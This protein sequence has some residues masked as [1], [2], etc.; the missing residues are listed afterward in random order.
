MQNIIKYSGLNNLSEEEQSIVKTIVEKEYPKIQ[1][2]IK[3][4]SDLTI[5]IKTMKKMT[6]KRFMINFKLE[7]PGIRFNAKTRD[8]ERG[9]DWDLAKACHKALEGLQ[10]EIK[11]R[12]KTDMEN[13]KKGSIKRTYKYLKD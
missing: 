11:H 5:N 8:T 13:W 9:G 7:A 6:R 4:I 3:N 10:F 2:V 12:L 1:R